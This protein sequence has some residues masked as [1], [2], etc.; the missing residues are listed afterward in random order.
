[1]FAVLATTSHSYSLQFEEQCQRQGLAIFPTIPRA[2]NAIAKMVRWW[3]MRQ[4][5]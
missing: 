2:C 5:A 1:V 3:E 4:D